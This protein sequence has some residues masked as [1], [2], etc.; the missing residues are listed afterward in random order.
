VRQ[1]RAAVRPSC[2]ASTIGRPTWSI[3]IRLP[4][5]RAVDLGVLRERA[6]VELLL[7]EEEVERALAA[8]VSPAA[9]SA[10]AIW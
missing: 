8:A 7:V 4:L 9:S 2:Q 6:V 1:S 5:R 10:V 3:C